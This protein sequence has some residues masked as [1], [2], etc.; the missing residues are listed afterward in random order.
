MITS[1]TQFYPSAVAPNPMEVDYWIDTKTDPNGTVIKT[2]NGKEWQQ[3]TD[4]TTDDSEIKTILEALNSMP[5]AIVSGSPQYTATDT[6]ISA[7]SMI[8]RKNGIKYGEA[9]EGNPQNIPAATK[10][11]AGVMTA[12][13]KTKLDN[14]E[15]S[16]N[17]AVA[18]LIG[19][20]PE[21]LDTLNELAAALGDDPNFA[22][23]MTES[24]ATKVDKVEGK[25]LSTNDYTT[26]EK[27]KLAGIA[28]NA[29]NY[30][31]PAA[32]EEQLGGIKKV[33]MWQQF[34]DSD[35]LAT[36]ITKLKSLCSDLQS[37]GILGSA[38]PIV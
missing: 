27:T 6:V 23:T 17:T 2:W 24:L 15:Q 18:N 21:T 10:T 5:E 4:T 7:V 13:D 16:I 28:A 38:D 8:N 37:A 1:K 31:L 32:T 30:T 26:E 34:A 33:S 14:M 22:T 19:S 36:V 3:I 35:D 12:A 25:S 11:T 29:N 20:A 9:Q